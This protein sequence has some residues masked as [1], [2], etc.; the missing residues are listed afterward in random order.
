[1]WIQTTRLCLQ[2]SG[3]EMPFPEVNTRFF[4]RDDHTGRYLMRV[5]GNG[6]NAYLTFKNE[7]LAN[8]AYHK[9]ATSVI[10]NI[11]VDRLVTIDDV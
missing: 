2:V 10:A 11:G 9:M 5:Y 8:E 3:F 7:K 6:L 4:A 1:M